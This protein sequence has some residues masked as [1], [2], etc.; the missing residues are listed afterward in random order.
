[1][2]RTQHTNH[3]QQSQPSPQPQEQ[4][5]ARTEASGCLLRVYWMML[6]NVLVVITAWQIAQS[7]SLLTAADLIFWLGVASLIGIRY[8]DV[9]YLRGRTAEGQPATMRDWRRYSLGIL[10]VSAILWI[11]LHAFS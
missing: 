1:M 6:G 4:D 3:E 7:D 8:A 9:R 5:A 10:G 2:N 11:A